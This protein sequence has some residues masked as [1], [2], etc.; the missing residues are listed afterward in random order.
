MEHQCRC[1]RR[2]LAK[3]IR[4][5][6]LRGLLIPFHRCSSYTCY[7]ILDMLANSLLNYQLARDPT[8]VSTASIGTRP[9][10]HPLPPE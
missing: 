8:S 4:F 1:C 9:S 6:E 5:V 2:S 7:L 10:P 3:S